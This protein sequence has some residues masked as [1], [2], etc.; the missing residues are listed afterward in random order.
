MNAHEGNQECAP[1]LKL[2]DET[3]GTPIPNDKQAAKRIFTDLSPNGECDEDSISAI[4]ERCL[5]KQLPKFI[6]KAKDRLLESLKVMLDEALIKMKREVEKSLKGDI[7]SSQKDLETKM[8][9]ENELLEMYNRRENVRIIGMTESTVLDANNK[10]IPEGPETSIQHVLNLAKESGAA[11]IQLN[12][13]SIAHRLPSRNKQQ[14]RPIIARFCR[15]ISK[16]DLL[17]SKKNLKDNDRYKNVKIFEDL[18]LPRIK[19]VNTI[20]RDDRIE[21][22]WTREGNIFFKW[23][24]DNKTN[25]VRGLYEGGILL[26]YNPTVVQQCFSQHGD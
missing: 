11:H 6:E 9:S 10:E 21:T 17:K 12:D 20:K 23:K 7:T 15:R 5:D 22:F 18:T 13:I 3:R 1:P 8:L 2:F 14:P 26:D 24:N 19:F 16:I 4:I 25:V